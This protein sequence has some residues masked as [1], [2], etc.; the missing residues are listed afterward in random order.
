MKLNI[1]FIGI[2]AITAISTTWRRR[3][4]SLAAACSDAKRIRTIR[5][6]FNGLWAVILLCLLVISDSWPIVANIIGSNFVSQ[7]MLW[8][9][10]LTVNP[11]LLIKGEDIIT[12]IHQHDISDKSI[13]GGHENA[14]PTDP[15]N[16]RGNDG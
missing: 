13:D 9:L 5:S 6:R 3:Q 4:I 1:L 2:I 12:R 15:R 11:D 8:S 10:A 16:R 14:A 7:L